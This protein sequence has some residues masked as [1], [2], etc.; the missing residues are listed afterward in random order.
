MNYWKSFTHEILTTLTGCPTE[1]KDVNISFSLNKYQT[2][3]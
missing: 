1:K 2:Q 3:T